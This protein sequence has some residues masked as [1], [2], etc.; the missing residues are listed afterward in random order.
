[1]SMYRLL[2][3]IV[4]DKLMGAYSGDSSAYMD[5]MY[6]N[7]Y[8]VRKAG[9]WEKSCN[10]IY[11]KLDEMRRELGYFGTLTY[12]TD[13]HDSVIFGNALIIMDRYTKDASS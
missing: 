2:S 3:N 12:I 4:G 8:K 1:M 7:I 5:S 9:K 11:M 13:F 10:E 6:T